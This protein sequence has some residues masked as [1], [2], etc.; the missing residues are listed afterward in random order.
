MNIVTQFKDQTYNISDLFGNF[1]CG[2]TDVHL[3]K[4]F[5]FRAFN[6]FVMQIE[7]KSSFLKIFFFISWRSARH[8]EL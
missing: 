6:E 1:E 4:V 5:F 8:Y 3:C 7:G 2:T